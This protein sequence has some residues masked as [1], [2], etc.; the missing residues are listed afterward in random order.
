MDDEVHFEF[1][2]DLEENQTRSLPLIGTHET[3]T[4]KKI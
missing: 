4:L 1:D 3:S 2:N